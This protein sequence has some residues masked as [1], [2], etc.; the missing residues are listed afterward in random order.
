M[1]YVSR[2]IPNQAFHC[3]RVIPKTRIELWGLSLDHE[4]VCY[5]S[6][7][8]CRRRSHRIWCNCLPRSVHC[9]L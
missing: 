7:Y 6:Y 1:A 3:V 4:S 9:C 5:L 2:I 8:F